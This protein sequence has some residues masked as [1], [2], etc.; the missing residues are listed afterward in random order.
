MVFGIGKKTEMPGQLQLIHYDPEDSSLVL[1]KISPMIDGTS[2]ISAENMQGFGKV[3]LRSVATIGRFLLNFVERVFFALREVFFGDQEYISIIQDKLAWLNIVEKNI[4]L[5]VNDLRARHHN[6][7]DVQQWM[8]Q[9]FNITFF[10]ELGIKKIPKDWGLY[11][12]I[13]AANANRDSWLGSIKTFFK[14]TG[15]KLHDWVR[16]NRSQFIKFAPNTKEAAIARKQN[17]RALLEF[18]RFVD[19]PGSDKELVNDRLEKLPTEVTYFISL[20]TYRAGLS[21]FAIRDGDTYT[22]PYQIGLQEFMSD[23]TSMRRARELTQGAIRRYAR[24]ELKFNVYKHWQ[25]L[26]A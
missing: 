18:Y 25:K 2:S 3:L 7:K 8:Q 21:G 13:G 15:Y 17:L 1:P 9:M 20:E 22:N 6:P 19:G 5:V 12:G 24:A 14:D 16:E 11:F 10:Y 26:L 4:D 23:R